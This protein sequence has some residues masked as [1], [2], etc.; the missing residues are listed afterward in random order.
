[1]N[2]H[3]FKTNK[4]DTGFANLI[5]GVGRFLRTAAQTEGL[6]QR[7]GEGGEACGI[8][9]QGRANAS[10]R[11]GLIQ[12]QG[13]TPAGRNRGRRTLDAIAS[14]HD[15]LPVAVRR[16]RIVR[17]SLSFRDPGLGPPGSLNRICRVSRM[18][19]P[20]YSIT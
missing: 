15:S 7:S 2:A 1:M 16:H 13:L 11:Q 4:N 8:G 10:L 19:R 20:L 14:C 3:R 17:G 5:R 12:R 9:K 18:N 6:F